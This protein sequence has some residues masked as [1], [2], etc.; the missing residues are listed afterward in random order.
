L[1][2]RLRRRRGKKDKERVRESKEGAEK[3]EPHGPT[4]GV[5]RK[6]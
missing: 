1:G 6:W 2:K 3:D 4:K 5:A